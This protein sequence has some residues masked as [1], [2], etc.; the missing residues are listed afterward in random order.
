[1]SQW[2]RIDAGVSVSEDIAEL[3]TR[4]PNAPLLFLMGMPQAFP[5]GILPANPAVFRAKVCPLFDLTL[6][7]V[8]ACLS[9]LVEKG[10]F[11]SY[12]DRQGKRLLYYTSWHRH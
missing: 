11:T 3:H 9:L 12:T 1:M 4:N 5:W 2:A 10:V 6:S 8:D 7:E